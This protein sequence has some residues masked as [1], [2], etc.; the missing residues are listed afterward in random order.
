MIAPLPSFD[1]L[2]E[3]DDLLADQGIE[4]FERPFQAGRVW[5]ERCGSL[6]IWMTSESWFAE[7]YRRLHPS[8]DF[9]LASFLTLCVSARGISYSVRPPVVL[10]QGVIRPR[11]Y[12]QITDNELG[13][14]FHRHPTEF[15]ELQWQALDAV[16]VF[17]ADLNFSPSNEAA[18]K[19][20][21]T[22]IHQLTASARQLVASQLDLSIPQGLA[23]ACELAGKAVL[24]GL[25]FGD[26]RL[27][28]LGHDLTKIHA[29][30][31]DE[32]PS[33][34]DVD[35]AANCSI[36]PDYSDVRYDAPLLTINEA[37]DLFRRAMFVVADFLR[38]TNHDQIYWREIES[39][40]MPARAF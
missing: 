21:S 32:L 36:I 30:I 35:V 22:S 13:R 34:V 8:T 4:I 31:Q 37:Q 6:A 10:G 16:E 3:I 27:R 1:E 24:G 18:R 7:A 14:I 11:E 20:M 15:W 12:V 29:A 2:V 5:G 9:S 38:R 17:A 40:E 28:E 25:G 23:M 26:E 33:P 39:G 19:R